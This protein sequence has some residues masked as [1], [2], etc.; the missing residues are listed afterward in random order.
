MFIENIVV[1]QTI[2]KEDTQCQIE[3]EYQCKN[4]TKPE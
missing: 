2:I 1:D 4:K 3:F